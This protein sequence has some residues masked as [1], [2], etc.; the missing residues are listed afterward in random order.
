MAYIPSDLPPELSRSRIRSYPSSVSATGPQFAHVA[1]CLTMLSYMQPQDRVSCCTALSDRSYATISPHTTSCRYRPL[2]S[3]AVRKPSLPAT[4]SR[5]SVDI[6]CSIFPASCVCSSSM[7]NIIHFPIRVLT[8]ESHRGLSAA[9][10]GV[11]RLEVVDWNRALHPA[12]RSGGAA[13]QS[14][15][16]RTRSVRIPQADPMQDQTTRYRG[17]VELECV[18]RSSEAIAR[19]GTKPRP[20][21]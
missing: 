17:A 13:G 14:H 19:C 15:A 21:Q 2:Y 4:S 1:C 16:E 3:L 12:R 11:S 5:Q 18:G 6:S 10:A 20:A 7:P 8:S 9:V